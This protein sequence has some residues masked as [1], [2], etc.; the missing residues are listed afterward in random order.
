M[1]SDFTLRSRTAAAAIRDQLLLAQQQVA[2]LVKDLDI[3]PL[4][5]Y[6][7]ALRRGRALARL[8]PL[9]SAETAAPRGIQRRSLK[10]LMNATLNL[11]D[12]DLL[13]LWLH[14]QRRS[15]PAA[16]SPHCPQL[17]RQLHAQRRKRFKAVCQWLQ[18]DDYEQLI[19]Q[20]QGAIDDELK[21]DANIIDVTR[22][23][24]TVAAQYRHVR[25]KLRK[26]PDK[27]D[28]NTLHDLRIA[29]KKLRY[30]T[31][32]STELDPAK[33][34]RRLE[35]LCRA[36]QSL[37]GDYNDHCVQQQL[38][39]GLI[40]RIDRED[41]ATVALAGAC[42][43]LSYEAGQRCRQQLGKPVSRFLQPKFHR[44]IVAWLNT[45]DEPRL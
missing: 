44:R 38:L 34:L 29:I 22:L 27:P 20:L 15:L 43:Q 11:R 42:C 26:L 8:L 32:F 35:K 41:P 9:G 5:Q 33:P 37:L 21:R 40:A 13:L 39:I 45:A 3:E 6:R 31:E 24:P 14:S 18:S 10:R 12:W 4:H 25:R 28:D 30:L 7:V 36:L 2:D 17:I 19:E 1:S 16:L 23:K